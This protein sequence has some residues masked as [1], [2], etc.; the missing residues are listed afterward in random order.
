[1]W[2]WVHSIFYV[3]IVYVYLLVKLLVIWCK[4]AGLLRTPLVQPFQQQ[5]DTVAILQGPGRL[6]AAR[7][8]KRK[9][10]LR[11]C[12]SY[13]DKY[14]PCFFKTMLGFRIVSELQWVARKSVFFYITLAI[15]RAPIWIKSQHPEPGVHPLLGHCLA[16][17]LSHPAQESTSLG[18]ST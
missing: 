9:L 3:Y 10:R 6:T 1:M 8:G 18:M 13:K 7:L 17:L 16:T 5:R 15:Q 12:E 14:S 11:D 4:G 2:I